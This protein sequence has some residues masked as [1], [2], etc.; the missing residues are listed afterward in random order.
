MRKMKSRQEMK[1][2]NPAQL[3][4]AAKRWYGTGSVSDLQ[5]DQSPIPEK[6][7]CSRSP[8]R[9]NVL[10]SDLVCFS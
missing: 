9:T 3:N 6:P 8:Y 2:P 1:I 5:L 10:W 4:Q 7:G